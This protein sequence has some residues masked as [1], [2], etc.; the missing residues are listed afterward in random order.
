MT[1]VGSSWAAERRAPVLKE[2]VEV[3]NTQIAPDVDLRR[4]QPG[5]QCVKYRTKLT[6]FALAAA[7]A[8]AAVACDGGSGTRRNEVEAANASATMDPVDQAGPSFP[9]PLTAEQVRDLFEVEAR[10][11]RVLAHVHARPVRRRV[12]EEH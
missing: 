10:P 11:R 5:R 8:L 7:I 3:T 12:V 2:V 9:V 6:P 4:V 1:A